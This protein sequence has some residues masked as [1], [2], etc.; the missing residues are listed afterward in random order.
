MFAEAFRSIFR[1]FHRW[2]PPWVRQGLSFLLIQCISM[3]AI[4]D[5]HEIVPGIW[6][7][8]KRA[9]QNNTWLK[10]EGI[11]VVFNATKDI[12]FSPMIKKQ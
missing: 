9:S 12:P 7:G 8:N 10:K 2:C 3:A 5:A 4:P 6:L 1:G 11:T